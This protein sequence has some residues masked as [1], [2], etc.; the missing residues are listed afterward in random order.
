MSEGEDGRPCIKWRGEQ[1]AKP[2]GEGGE[3]V[4]KMKEAETEAEEKTETEN[5][6]DAETKLLIMEYQ[7]NNNPDPTTLKVQVFL[8]EKPGGRMKGQI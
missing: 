1:T 5:P 3:T 4:Q 8:E 7:K 2:T 6:R